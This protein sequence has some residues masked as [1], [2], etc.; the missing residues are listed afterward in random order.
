MLMTV[1]DA[2]CVLALKKRSVRI[3]DL[4]Y[5]MSWLYKFRV[6]QNRSFL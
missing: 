2:K 1:S 5:K 6:H 3:L 4:I